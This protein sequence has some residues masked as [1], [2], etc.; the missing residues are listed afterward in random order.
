MYIGDDMR[1]HQCVAAYLSDYFLAMSTTLPFRHVG[2]GH[3]AS[4]DHSLWFHC[5][6]RTDEWML[7]ECESP[8]TGWWNFHS[9]IK[10]CVFCVVWGHTLYIISEIEH[11]VCIFCWRVL[12][13]DLTYIRCCN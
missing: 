12:H 3:L 2:F 13:S 1:M 6:F 11:E 4:L 10:L 7:Y 8:K 9:I 5:P